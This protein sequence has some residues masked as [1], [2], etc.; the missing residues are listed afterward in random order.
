MADEVIT[1]A[2]LTAQERTA[3]G[4]L[5]GNVTSIAKQLWTVREASRTVAPKIMKLYNTLAAKYERLGGFVGFARLFDNTIPLK[6]GTTDAPGYRQHKTYVALDYMRR[7]IRVRPARG[8]QGRRDPATDQLGRA[9][10]TIVQIVKGDAMNVVWDAIATE[11]GLSERAI[12]RLKSRVGQVSPLID[13]KAIKPI[14]VTPSNVIHV[15][16]TPASSAQESAAA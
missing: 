5:K 7:L 11:F 9:L 14:N 8:T 12:A 4:D 10:A 2:D 16:A 15:A 6:A 13:L 3:V 1:L